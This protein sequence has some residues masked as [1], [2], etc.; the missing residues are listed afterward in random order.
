MNDMGE[1]AYS[2]KM[3]DIIK[4]MVAEELQRERPQYQ[5]ATVSA[6]D[7]ANFKAS[8]IFTG[9]TTA[10]TVNTG[11]FA[12][13]LS[14][15]DVVRVDGIRTDK[16]VAEIKAWSGKAQL[17]APVN[18]ADV[19]S[20]GARDAAIS[21]AVLAE[22]APLAQ[23]SLTTASPASAFPTG[24]STLLVDPLGSNPVSDYGSLTT[25]RPYINTE[26]G[27]TYQYFTAY[28]GSGPG[29][30]YRQWFYT[31]VAWSAWQ[32][33][34]TVSARNTAIAV[35]ATGYRL[36][37]VLYLTAGTTFTK[38]TYPWLR[39]LRVKVQAGGGG[40]GG[41]N[42]TSAA[43]A[44]SFG[45]GGGGGGYAEAFI[46]NIAGLAAST[47][48][49]VG[50]GGG[51]GNAWGGGAGGA[52]SFGAL[53]VATGGAGG[54]TK[55]NDI[56]GAYVATAAGGVGTSGDILVSGGSGGTGQT[57]GA[58]LSSSGCGG[59]SQ[60]GGGGIS[61]AWGGSPYQTNGSPGGQY[62]GGAGGGLSNAS[63]A[64]SWGGNAAPGI[65]I[66]ELYA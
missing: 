66:V 31:A 28:Q 59:S 55:A 41:S 40:G 2:M 32:Q 19:D 39:A 12:K 65:V 43:P 51:G 15:N 13:F 46:T 48:V 60:L 57:A 64:A 61:R 50:G 62:G 18:A 11:H 9:D 47:T 24:F 7:T 63:S 6:L 54:P 30:W 10:V 53:V 3:R 16:F 29:L 17:A 37:Q 23:N 34:D 14:V 58:G 25:I 36:N 20:K 49:T 4:D 33:V 8:V 38:A 26:T 21:A 45:Q 44:C 35:V 52:S 5:Y 22:R 27:G 42:A 56:Y 1:L